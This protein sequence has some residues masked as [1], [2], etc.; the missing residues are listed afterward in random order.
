MTKSEA[1]WKGYKYF[2][3]KGKQ[4]L[5]VWSRGCI[6]VCG[7]YIS[8]LTLT[9]KRLGHGKCKICQKWE[10]KNKENYNII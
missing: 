4:H 2:D 3:E 8:P 6:P 9:S 7:L 5:F 1:R 10:R